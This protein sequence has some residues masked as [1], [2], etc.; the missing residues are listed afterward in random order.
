MREPC[1]RPLYSPHP[2]SLPP[3]GTS[4]PSGGAGT[5]TA[6]GV[7]EVD[8]A[9][10]RVVA[11]R[12]GAEGRGATLAA[13]A[14]TS[15]K[16]RRC[17]S[18]SQPLSN[19]SRKG[20]R[21]HSRQR[22]RSTDAVWQPQ[23]RGRQMWSNPE[24]ATTHRCTSGRRREEPIQW[25]QVERGGRRRRRHA[26]VDRNRAPRVSGLHARLGGGRP[27]ADRGERGLIKGGLRTK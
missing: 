11:A 14:S 10:A 19:T 15:T 9:A 27:G 18:R 26:H 16:P 7:R 21:D 25:E 13:K 6:R 17:Q 22:L 20:C 12:E 8:S 23:R 24:D 4:H 3:P 2:S 5:C 1:T